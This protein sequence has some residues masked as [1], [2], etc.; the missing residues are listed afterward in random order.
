MCDL[1]Q[2]VLL[3]QRVLTEGWSA[4]VAWPA[5]GLQADVVS[6][7]YLGRLS[8]AQ[9]GI[10]S[11]FSPFFLYGPSLLSICLSQVWR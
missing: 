6:C 8:L 10:S 3:G 5:F 1:A 4:W 11:R 2:P 7:V 9:D